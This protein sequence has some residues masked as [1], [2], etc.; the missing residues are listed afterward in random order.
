[1]RIKILRLANKASWMAVENYVT[2]P[3]C[4]NDEDD[5]KWKKAVKEAKEELKNKRK[6]YLWR[7]QLGLRDGDYGRMGYG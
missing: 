1:M 6:K 7:R 2:D 5:R 4:E 3:L